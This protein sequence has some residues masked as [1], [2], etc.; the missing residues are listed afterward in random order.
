MISPD[1]MQQ[2]SLGQTLLVNC[3]SERHGISFL[4]SYVSVGAQVGV[5]AVK[6]ELRSLSKSSADFFHCL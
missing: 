5:F 1:Q 2:N 3:G 6:N 4:V